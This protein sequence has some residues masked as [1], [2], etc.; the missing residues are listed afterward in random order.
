MHINKQNIFRTVGSEV[1]S[2]V[3]NPVYHYSIIST[4]DGDV[5]TFESVDSSLSLAYQGFYFFL[6]VGRVRQ[7]T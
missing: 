1:S 5:T 2:C 3:G 6:S 7:T 4:R